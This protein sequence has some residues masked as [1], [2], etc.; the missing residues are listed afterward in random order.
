M[1]CRLVLRSRS[2][3]F[4]SLR[5][6]SSG[7][8]KK[9]EKNRKTGHPPFAMQS[10]LESLQNKPSPDVIHTALDIVGLPISAHTACS[11]A[12]HNVS[13]LDQAG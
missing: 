6:F 8:K 12:G 7:T 2:Q 10:Q 3:F 13:I 5:H 11:L 9:Q 4:H 1:S